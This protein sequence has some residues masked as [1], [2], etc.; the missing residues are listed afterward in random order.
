MPELSQ[1]E[2]I[3]NFVSKHPQSITSRRICR[4]I[5]GEGLERINQEFADELA[6]ELKESDDSTIESY[7]YLIR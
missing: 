5:L 6:A 3:V 7:Y 1:I 2:A 4:E